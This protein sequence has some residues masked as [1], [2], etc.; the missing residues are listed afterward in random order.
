M[1]LFFSLSALFISLT[2]IIIYTNSFTTAAVNNE[3]TFSIVSEEN[4]LIAI[5][6]TESKNL[7][8]SNNTDKSIVVKSIDLVSDPKHKFINANLPIS[9]P[10]GS[11]Q[12]FTI[13][14]NKK[15]L[16]GEVL[17]VLV[18]WSGGT[19]NIKSIMPKMELKVIT[20]ESIEE[21][22]EPEVNDEK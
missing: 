16:S 9:L 19:A 22:I 3:A 12:Q 4:A 20:P 13:A 6:Y 1:R 11:N 18:H 15:D 14:N 17:T 2:M 8:L 7:Q 21:L 5:N 10:P